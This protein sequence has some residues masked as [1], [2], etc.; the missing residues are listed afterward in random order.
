MLN[1]SSGLIPLE[2]TILTQTLSSSYKSFPSVSLNN[3]RRRSGRGK[4]HISWKLLFIGDGPGAISISLCRRP[5]DPLLPFTLSLSLS[6]SLR[7]SLNQSEKETRRGAPSNV[8][9]YITLQTWL[10]FRNLSV[11]VCVCVCG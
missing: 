6:L 4:A 8:Q 7:L 1:F 2:P 3:E 11:C 9:Y 10:K 5:A